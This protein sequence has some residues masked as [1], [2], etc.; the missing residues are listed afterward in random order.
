MIASHPPVKNAHKKKKDTKN[1]LLPTMTRRT[2]LLAKQAHGPE[3]D[4]T[5]VLPKIL[6]KLLN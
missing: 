2:H 1:I 5:Y 4:L 6:T 3:K